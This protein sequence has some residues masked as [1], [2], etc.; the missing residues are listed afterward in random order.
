MSGFRLALEWWGLPTRL[1]WALAADGGA[2]VTKL[3]SR[4]DAWPWGVC[5]GI[6]QYVR[7]YSMYNMY[8][9]YG[10][11]GMYSRYICTVGTYVCGYI[12]I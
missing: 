9:I 1:E 3:G 4:L 12:C 6:V 5:I 10:M 8:G 2:R 11:Y 7:M